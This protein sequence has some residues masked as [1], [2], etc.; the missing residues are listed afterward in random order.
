MQLLSIKTGLTTLAS[1]AVVVTFFWAVEQHYVS[2]ADFEQFQMRQQ[3]Q[4]DHFQT[5][6]QRNITDFRRQM[7]E[8]DLFELDLKVEEGTA[9]TID[10]ARKQR[11]ERQLE[12]L[13]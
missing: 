8:D 7:L 2:A 6:Q 5:Q 12:R 11:I 4:F 9:N 1:I 13:Q 10:R 3:Q